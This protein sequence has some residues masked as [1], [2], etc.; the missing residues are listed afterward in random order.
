MRAPVLLL[1]ALL[2][3]G[4]DETANAPSA[5][6]CGAPAS[7]PPG[8]SARQLQLAVYE[9]S[10]LY[11]SSAG[12]LQ[13]RRGSPLA[14]VDPLIP[15]LHAA[16][17]AA[18]AGL[19]QQLLPQPLRIHID[20]RL[21]ADEAGLRGVEVH[22]SSRELL[23]E[24]GALA[25]LTAEAWRHELLHSLAAPPPPASEV[26]R[27]L[28]LTLEE[29][30]VEHAAL[31]GAPARAAEAPMPPGLSSLPPVWEQLALPAYDPHEL[32]HGWANELAR[33]EPPLDLPSAVACLSAAPGATALHTLQHTAQAFVQR[34]PPDVAP[35]LQRALQRWLAEEWHP[36]GWRAFSLQAR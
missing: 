5:L 18:S 23:L 10:R 33:T 4:A 12:R 17:L 6:P 15:S 9:H 31:L 30:L 21:P 19:P 14:C 13:L 11:A 1:L 28:W 8:D 7:A 26:A 36:E 2:I 24:R 22:V 35:V 32:A 27:R 34:C 25:A 20:P 16:L 29:G 3:S